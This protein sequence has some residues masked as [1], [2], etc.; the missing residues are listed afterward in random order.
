MTRAYQGHNST[1]TGWCQASQEKKPWQH[2]VQLSIGIG[3][4]TYR[5]THTAL[6]SMG[7]AQLTPHIR[8][9]SHPTLL[10]LL[11]IDGQAEASKT[12][13]LLITLWHSDSA[14]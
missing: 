9:E 5:T 8:Q 12:K 11:E 2:D 6:G 3:A 7:H 4:G 10:T 13:T 1:M 14:L